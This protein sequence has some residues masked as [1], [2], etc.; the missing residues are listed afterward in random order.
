[1]LGLTFVALVGAT[2]WVP[3]D[4]V[5]NVGPRWTWM[6]HLPEP[7]IDLSG[8]ALNVINDRYL[9]TLFPPEKPTGTWVSAS[10]KWPW[11]VS[12]LALVVTLGGHLALVLRTRQARG[13][14]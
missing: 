7:G 13:A 1:M 3:V 8:G 4:P 10:I 14:A 12:Q 2:L 11:L 9:T 5:A 6:W